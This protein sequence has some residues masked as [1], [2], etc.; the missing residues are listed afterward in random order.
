M[1]QNQTRLGRVLRLARTDRH[2]S[3]RAVAEACGTNQSSVA[4]WE[5]GK[6]QPKLGTLIICSQF[7][8]VDAGAL[9]EAAALDLEESRSQVPETVDL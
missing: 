9:V 3:Q 2:V 6:V 1:A 8:G 7:L 4:A 5:S